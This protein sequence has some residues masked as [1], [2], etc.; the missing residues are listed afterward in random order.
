MTDILQT[1]VPVVAIVLGALLALRLVLLI[2]GWIGRTRRPEARAIRVIGVGGGGS[3][4][5]DRMVAA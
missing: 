5:V 1:V 4:A 2:P 3:N